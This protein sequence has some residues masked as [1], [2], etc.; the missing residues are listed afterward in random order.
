MKRITFYTVSSIIA[1]LFL[2]ENF[3]IAQISRP[4]QPR[5]LTIQTAECKITLDIAPDLSEKYKLDEQ[6]IKTTAEKSATTAGIRIN[7]GADNTIII[8][9]T[10]HLPQK[11]TLHKKIDVKAIFTPNDIMSIAEAENDDFTGSSNTSKEMSF[12]RDST[13]GTIILNAV[14]SVSQIVA[15]E[16][17]RIILMRLNMKMRDDDMDNN[18]EDIR[19]R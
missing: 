15:L 19:I 14:Q 3:I 11:D 5:P 7:E 10:N 1:L 4:R 9:I 18:N 12:D 13:S 8:L 17:N 16:A 2:S 6:E